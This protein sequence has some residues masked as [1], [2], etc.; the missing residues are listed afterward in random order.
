MWGRRAGPGAPGKAAASSDWMERSRGW[1]RGAHCGGIS[2]VVFWGSFQGGGVGS[3]DLASL[4][5]APALL[6]ERA[7][8]SE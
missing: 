6:G 4:W 3:A 7:G 8:V 2:A 5:P 1:T